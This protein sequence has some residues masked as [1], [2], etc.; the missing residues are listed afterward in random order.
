[1]EPVTQQVGILN[2]A[3][4]ARQ[5]EKNGLESVFGKVPVTHDLAADA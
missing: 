4:L 3:S 1:M 5:H 2:R